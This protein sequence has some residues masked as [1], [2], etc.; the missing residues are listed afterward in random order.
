MGTIESLA[1][2]AKITAVIRLPDG[3]TVIG[4]VKASDLSFEFG[5]MCVIGVGG[6]AYIVGKQNVALVLE[7]KEKEQ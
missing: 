3:S 4:E 7:N 2:K 1:E 5:E 6:K